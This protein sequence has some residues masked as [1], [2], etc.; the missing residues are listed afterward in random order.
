M[1]NYCTSHLCQPITIHISPI[2]VDFRP[3]KMMFIQ[4]GRISS[5][6]SGGKNERKFCGEKLS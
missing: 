6:K 4:K 2:L 3:S 5:V 1:E